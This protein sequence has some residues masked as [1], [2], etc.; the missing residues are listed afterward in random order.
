MA[1]DTSTEVVP[2]ADPRLRAFLETVAEAV[3]EVILRDLDQRRE[4][5]RAKGGES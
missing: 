5:A 2:P 1:R 4:A 3:A